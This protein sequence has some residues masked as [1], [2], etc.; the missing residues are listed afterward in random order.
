MATQRHNLGLAPSVKAWD[1]DRRDDE[2]VVSVE[3][4]RRSALGL[5]AAVVARF[6]Q[7]DE[8]EMGE[9]RRMLKWVAKFAVS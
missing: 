2:P 4:L 7:V 1:V 3:E 6:G 5:R 9:L 8:A